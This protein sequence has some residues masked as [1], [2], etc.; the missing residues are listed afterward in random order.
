MN[1][2]SIR[3]KH[4]QYL[5]LCRLSGSRSLRRRVLAFGPQRYPPSKIGRLIAVKEQSGTH[6][7]SNSTTPFKSLGSVLS[8]YGESFLMLT[9]AVFTFLQCFYNSGAS[10]ITDLKLLN[11]AFITSALDD[12]QLNK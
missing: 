11:G 6:N 8:F 7:I 9:K 2:S 4:T 12:E 5:L 1:D 10:L 3:H